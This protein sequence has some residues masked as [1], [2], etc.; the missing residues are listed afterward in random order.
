MKNY[1]VVSFHTPDSYYSGH[2]REMMKTLDRFGIPHDVEVVPPV[3][4]WVENC[5]FKPRFIQRKLA[6]HADRPVVWLDADARVLRDPVL[7]EEIPAD[8]AVHY[9]AGQEMLSNAMFFNVG[10]RSREL[11]DA[12]VAAQEKEPREWDQRVLQALIDRKALAMGL[13]IQLLPPEYAAIDFMHVAN[14]VIVQ[15]QASRLL[16]RKGQIKDERRCGMSGQA[17][18]ESP[19]SVSGRHPHRHVFRRA[20]PQ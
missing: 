14:P 17:L 2:A 8:F 20:G 9:R 5:A 18:V 1:V 6:E 13:E 10:P 19:R 4:C 3:G 12:W 15:M 11:V 7:F 16:R